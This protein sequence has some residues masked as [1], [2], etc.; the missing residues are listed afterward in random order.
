MIIIIL[1][2]A[3]YRQPTSTQPTQTQTA[4]IRG[5]Y[6]KYD[7]IHKSGSRPTQRIVTANIA[8]VGLHPD[9]LSAKSRGVAVTTSGSRSNSI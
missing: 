2:Y 5:K 4:K 9:P 6:G 1:Y 8:L 3:I 7:V